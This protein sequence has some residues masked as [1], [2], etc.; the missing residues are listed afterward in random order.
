MRSAGVTKADPTVAAPLR[1]RVLDGRYLVTGA[2]GEW[3]VLT[4]D[5]FRRLVEGDVTAGDG[6][7]ERLAE[8]HLLVGAQDHVEASVRRARRR[9]AFL[10]E[11]PSLHVMSLTG[12][13][14]GQVM[15][16]DL[17]DRAVD[18]AFMTTASALTLE[19]VAT[20]S[21]PPLELA[22]RVA[23]YALGKNT[24]ARK[25]LTLALTATPSALDDD[26]LAWI[27]DQGVQLRA[28]VEPAALTNGGDPSAARLRELHQRL[29]DAGASRRAEAVVVAAPEALTVAPSWVDA[30]AEL[31]CERLTLAPV[32]AFPWP[33][34][35]EPPYPIDAWLAF[36]E[37]TLDRLL[38]LAAEG[39]A[40]RETLAA[41]LLA[42]ILRGDEP[43]HRDVRNPGTDAL[44]QLAYGWDG[45]VY[46]S[47]DGRRLGDLGD[48]M[49]ALGRVDTS[50]YHDLMAHPTVRAALLATA[51]D[52]Q[53]DCTSCAYNPYC[54]QRPV[55]NYAQQGSLQGRMRD[56][57]TCRK[58]KRIQDM[59]F[60][61]L[62]DATLRPLLEAWTA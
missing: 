48:P 1:Y 26:D 35:S 61:R 44:G 17:A 18:T 27:V 52:G 36:Y 5:E 39:G 53:P 37:A 60:T 12:P 14:D 4:A 30:V 22:R 2:M 28:L 29:A 62:G 51:L 43:G 42:R 49:F 7:F 6:L 25:D 56:S 47:D 58:H 33:G 10:R 57:E 21:A 54:G 8:R 20:D 59:L 55:R 38:A 46:T 34:L 11:G 32:E 24:L 40:L 50:G 31:G 23:S 41:A 15:A 9:W 45:V 3:I 13:E 16:R 19:L